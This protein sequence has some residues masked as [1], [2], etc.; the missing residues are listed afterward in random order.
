MNRIHCKRDLLDKNPCAWLDLAPIKGFCV[1]K[2]QADKDR[3]LTRKE[4]QSLLNTL[5]DTQAKHKAYIQNYAIKFA[6]MTGMRVSELAALKWECITDTVLK[7][8]YSEHRL[9]YDDKPCEYIIG[10]PKNRKHRTFPMSD[11]MKTL[12]K[13]IKAVH[14]EYGIESEFVFADKNGRVNSH[15]ISCAMSRRCADAGIESRNIHAIR[16]TVSSYLRTVLPVATVANMPRHLE[17]TNEKYYNYD[18][19]ETSEKV[20]CLNLM[21]QTFQTAKKVA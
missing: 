17:E 15:T 11:E 3:I 13:R 5:H 9:D 19:M 16:R 1:V 7:I 21:N 8:D 12:F 2:A 20:D 6:S 4:M 10:E 14:D 18:I